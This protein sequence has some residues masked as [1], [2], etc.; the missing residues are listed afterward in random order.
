MNIL[1][2]GLIFVFL[3]LDLLTKRWMEDHLV[4]EEVNRVIDGWLSW[5]LIHNSG[6]SF[7]LFSGHMYSLVTI[8]LLVTG[9]IVVFYARSRKS[10]FVH[11]G[12]ALLISGALGNL[13]NRIHLG[14]VVDFI[15]FRFWPAVFNFA[16]IQIRTGIVLLVILYIK[17]TKKLNG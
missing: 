12:F 10:L 8:Q 7:G 5:K 2:Y 1:F 9:L 4:L 3:S 14:Y 15:S 6:A 17:Y 16:D 11:F 13:I